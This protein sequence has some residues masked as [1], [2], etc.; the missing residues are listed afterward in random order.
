VF[1][2]PFFGKHNSADAQ[3]NADNRKDQSCRRD[4]RIGKNNVHNKNTGLPQF[5][6]AGG[7]ACLAAS[8]SCEP[9][10][11]PEIVPSDIPVPMAVRLLPP[12][13]GTT[14]EFAVFISD[15]PIS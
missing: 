6:R 7:V 3:D 12:K 11:V 9:L 8:V 2:I 5:I 13:P 10:L 14:P 1:R 15:V 4:R